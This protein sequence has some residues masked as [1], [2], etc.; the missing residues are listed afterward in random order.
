MLGEIVIP[1]DSVLQNT[2]LT[3]EIF[4]QNI[5]YLTVHAMLELLGFDVSEN[6]P[7]KHSVK[8]KKKS[9]LASLGVDINRVRT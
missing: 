5:M 3:D 8:E 7:E 1:I 6:S 2:D 4:R 9:I